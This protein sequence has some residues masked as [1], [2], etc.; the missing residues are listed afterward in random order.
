MKPDAFLVNTGRGALVDEAALI[1]ALEAGNIAVAGL[2]VLLQEP[3]APYNPLL[4]MEN[5]L[6]TGHS[7]ASTVEAPLAW[8]AEWRD[9]ISDYLAGWLPQT[10]VNPTVTPKETLKIKTDRTQA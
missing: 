3:P 9:I 2:D 1:R 6:H 10:V 7:A 8:Q 4:K 5:V